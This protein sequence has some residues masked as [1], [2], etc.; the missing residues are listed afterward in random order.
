MPIS[1]HQRRLIHGMP[2]TGIHGGSE[3]F[4]KSGMSRSAPRS[5]MRS[6]SIRCT[7]RQCIGQVFFFLSRTSPVARWVKRRLLMLMLHEALL[8]DQELDIEDCE[9]LTEEARKLIR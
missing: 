4:S 5:A 6:D 8:R 3:V 9:R 1:A 7:S 2:F